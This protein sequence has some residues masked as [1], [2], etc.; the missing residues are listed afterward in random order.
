MKA[1]EVT[2]EQLSVLAQAVRAWIAPYA[3]FGVWRPFGRRS[4]KKMK[5]LSHFIDADG[6]WRC[7]EVP[8]PDSL[9]AWEACWRVFRTA[10]IMTDLAAPAV[11]DRYAAQF[12]QRVE[13]FPDAWHLCVEADQR[14]RS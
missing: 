9:V 4:A 2:D 7:R 8:G 3:G 11:L 14:C 12:R 10:A 13:R 5:F 6:Q 1:E